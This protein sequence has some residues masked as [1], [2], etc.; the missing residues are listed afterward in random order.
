MRIIHTADWHL[1]NK[2]GDNFRN[3]RTEDQFQRVKVVAELCLENAVDVLVIAGDIF[4][5]RAS[6]EQIDEALKHIYKCFDVF[7]R[8][9][10]TILSITGNHDRDVKL[11]MVRIGMNLAMPQISFAEALPAGR[12]YIVNNPCVLKLKNRSGVAVQFVLLPY[13]NT[14]RYALDTQAGTSRELVN[15]QV[16]QSVLDQVKLLAGKIDTA[17]QTVL[18]AHLNV[19]GSETNALYRLSEADDHMFAFSDLQTHWAYVALGH[20]HKP[21]K[22]GGA[23]HVRYPGSLDRLDFGETHDDHGVLLCD[24][25]PGQPV[26]PKHLPIAATPFWTITLDDPDTQLPEWAAKADAEPRAIVLVHVE[27]LGAFSR[28]ELQ[29]AIRS[30]FPRL[31]DVRWNLRDAFHTVPITVNRKAE[32]TTVVRDYVTAQ[33]TGEDDQAEVLDLLETYL[34]QGE[35]A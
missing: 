34:A 1:C 29:R 4:C 8:R 3:D 2:L 11:N 25:V 10:G 35:S 15:S 28:D 17:L 12:M 5:D 26:V 20:I 32:F 22:L 33:T 13:P 19:S 31:H 24:I 9:G 18:V 6:N 16:R 21:Q 23:E 14:Y 7:F 27:S 30:A